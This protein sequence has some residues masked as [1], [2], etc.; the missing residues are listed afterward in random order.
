MSVFVVV[1]VPTLYCANAETVV[2]KQTAIVEII[3]FI[4]LN[5]LLLILFF[6]YAIINCQS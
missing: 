5:V 6:L 1:E 2:S 4:Y 3:F